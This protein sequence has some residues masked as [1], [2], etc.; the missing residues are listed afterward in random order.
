MRE[1]LRIDIEGDKFM[2]V[3]PFW[4]NELVKQLPSRRW[5][6]S[7][8][9]WEVP[10]LRQTAEGVR[11][12]AQNPGVYIS[13]KALDALEAYLKKMKKKVPAEGEEFP[14]WFPFKRKPRAHQKKVLDKKWSRKSFALH[15]DMGTGKTYTEICY[16]SALRMTGKIESM[17]V[18][19]KLSGRRNWVE[20]FGTG[21]PIP[22][23]IHLPTTD[24]AAEFRRW[25]AKPHD[26]KIM[27]VGSES[28]SQGGMWKMVE[29]FLLKS[30]R[31]FAVVDESHLFANHRSIRTERLHDFRKYCDYRDSMTGTP[32]SKNPLDLFAQFEWLD[33][34]I[35]G[36]GDFYAFRNRYASI[37]QQKLKSGK[38]FPLVIGYQ[39]IDELTRLIAPYTDE[40]R[41]SDVLELPP[42]NYLPHLYLQMTPA[43]KKLYQ[44][45]KSSG[46]YGER[47]ESIVKNVLEKELRLH[48]VAQGWVP[49]Y[50]LEN[51]LGRGGVVKQR[52]NATWHPIIPPKDNPKIMEL[53][54]VCAADRQFIIWCT[55]RPA[56]QAIYECLQDE[57][58]KESIVQ[59]H[60]GISEAD[61]ATFRQEYQAGKHKFM[62]GN[63]QTGG[64]ADTWTA[65]ETMVYF[66][67]ANRMVDRAQSE[68]RAHRDGLTH[69]VDYLDLVM[70]G[71]VDTVRM[72]AIEMKMDLAEYVRHRIREGSNPLDA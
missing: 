38:T 5:S 64:T 6:K 41:K 67:N 35:I 60:G 1:Q 43:Q 4:A 51:Y 12:L 56:L 30:G 50:D 61:R 36:I 11:N 10:L 28:L 55:Y 27:V 71:T 22:Y 46:K 57:Y 15:H 33:P 63:T 17:L 47:E 25:L 16:G 48:Q 65:C 29:E 13:E 8:R 40:V 19:V 31:I 26:F 3:C 69:V 49:E 62:L 59:I 44:Q 34:D 53:L 42:K 14:H 21:C 37:I 20:Q 58:P 2:I 18:I 52:K 23:S 45:I 72:K 68:D 24:E 7:K 9:R 39:N 54:D 70:E 66:D 32:I